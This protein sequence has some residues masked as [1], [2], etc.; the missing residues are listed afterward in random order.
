MDGPGV[1]FL[2]AGSLLI[3][4][5]VWLFYVLKEEMGG[6]DLHFSVLFF[7]L[8]LAFASVL[9]YKMKHLFDL[10]RLSGISEAK[11]RVLAKK[12]AK[13]LDWRVERDNAHY[14][15]ASLGASAFSWGEQI[16]ILYDETDVLINVFS[17]GS[18]G[19]KSPFS[20]GNKAIHMDNFEML[21]S[22]SIGKNR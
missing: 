10:K 4:S 21:F 19:T 22:A 16:T 20:F 5:A 12:I 11:N 3:N 14:L 15:I 2:I 17:K 7:V 18:F 13:E 9:G 8:S 6:N 1:A